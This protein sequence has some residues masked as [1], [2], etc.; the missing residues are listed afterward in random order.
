MEAKELASKR[1][2]ILEEKAVV[3]EMMG[4]QLDILRNPDADRNDIL[5]M[6]EAIVV[7]FE[8]S[9]DDKQ[10]SLKEQNNAH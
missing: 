9:A 10:K 4:L 2:K 1:Q 8:S 5:D 6:V 3:I 7:A